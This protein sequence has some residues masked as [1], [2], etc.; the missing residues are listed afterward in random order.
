MAIA[1][2]ADSGRQVAVATSLTYAFTTA[3]SDRQL[4]VGCLVTSNT[5]S[6]V[7][8]NGVSASQIATTAADSGVT[9][10]TYGLI[11]PATG[12][13]NVVITATGSTV[14]V[15]HSVYYTGVNQTTL[16]DGTA[17]VQTGSGNF[18]QSVTTVADNCWAILYCR[19]GISNMA[20][21]SATTARSSADDNMWF[22]SNSAKTPAGSVTLAVTSVTGAYGSIIESISPFVAASSL[23][24]TANGLANASVKTFDGLANASTKTV[25]GL[26]NV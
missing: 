18:T 19:N 3:G 21:G 7:T 11:A 9:I 24:K 10:F 2:G 8:Y 25:D 5:I 20:A 6:T 1:F 14:L 22:D 17:G 13:N 23:V 26:T 16:T 15:S 4:R 12:S